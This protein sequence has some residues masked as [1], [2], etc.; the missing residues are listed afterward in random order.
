MG[1]PKH[2]YK[3]CKCYKCQIVHCDLKPENLLLPDIVNNTKLSLR[4][5]VLQGMCLQKVSQHGVGP[6]SLLHPRY[7]YH[8]ATM[9]HLCWKSCIGSKM[10]DWTV[11]QNKLSTSLGEIKV[12]GAQWHL[13]GAVHAIKLAK[14]MNH[15]SVHVVPMTNV[16]GV[17]SN[18]NNGFE[19]SRWHEKD[20]HGN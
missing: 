17:P 4:T 13:M 12:F 16:M 6:L 8:L 18:H 5:L 19:S 15:F 11:Q 7:W 14:Q 1:W 2:S 10:S 20:C 3:P 9:A